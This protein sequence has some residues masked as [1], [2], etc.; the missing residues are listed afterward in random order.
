M[1]WPCLAEFSYFE[2]EIDYWKN[3]KKKEVAEVKEPTGQDNLKPK[4]TPAKTSVSSTKKPDFEWDKYLNPE[5]DE[6]FMEEGKLPPKPLMEAARRPTDENIK[7]WFKFIDLKNRLMNRF[8]FAV[9]RYQKVVT[10]KKINFTNTLQKLKQNSTHPNHRRFF[11]RMFFSSTCPHCK[12]MFSTLK[13]LQSF[14][15][16]AEA[17]QVDRGPPPLGFGVP[18]Y[19]ANPSEIK[20]VKNESVPYTVILDSKTKNLIPIRGFHTSREV[21]SVINS[22]H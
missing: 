2:E 13:K 12:R 14:G 5:N 17:L 15:F 8:L 7:N 16:Y 1:S 6:F 22:I 3:N 19:Q 21:L 18:I 10:A 11:I 4:T 9:Q 20:K